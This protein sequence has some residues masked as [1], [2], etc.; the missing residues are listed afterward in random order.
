MIILG[1]VLLLLG[2]FLFSPLVIVGI[3]VLVI[4]LVLALAGGTGRSIGGRSHW[5]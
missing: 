5:Y 4:G 1:I 2:L 3:I